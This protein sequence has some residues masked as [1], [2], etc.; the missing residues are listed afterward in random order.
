MSPRVNQQRVN[1]EQIPLCK[2]AKTITPDITVYNDAKI[3]D[4]VDLRVFQP[5]DGMICN[6]KE[7]SKDPELKIGSIKILVCI[8]MY[9]EGSGAIQQTL[10][11]IYDNL[12]YLEG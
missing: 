11:G 7:I 9:N 12:K 8:C 3:P 5:Q 2:Y 10:E 6:F 1:K 4:R